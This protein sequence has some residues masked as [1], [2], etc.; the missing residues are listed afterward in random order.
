[1]FNSQP[2]L[3]ISKVDEELC[4]RNA[5][6]NRLRREGAISE[7]KIYLVRPGTFEALQDHIL[8]AG[9]TTVQYKSP[10][11]LKNSETLEF[12]MKHT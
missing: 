11:K 8:S 10:R 2:I 6:Y 9:G 5:D 3:P 4:L 7:P 12:L 1:M